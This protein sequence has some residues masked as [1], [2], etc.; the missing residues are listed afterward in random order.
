MIEGRLFVVVEHQCIV[1][2]LRKMLYKD[3]DHSWDRSVTSLNHS[4]SNL[5][6]FCKCAFLPNWLGRR[7]HGCVAIFCTCLHMCLHVYTHMFIMFACLYMFLLLRWILLMIADYHPIVCAF[8]NVT[9]SNIHMYVYINKYIYIYT[10]RFVLLHSNYFK[11]LILYDYMWLYVK[12]KMHPCATRGS[13]SQAILPRLPAPHS[14]FDHRRPVCCES[15][16]GMAIMGDI[17][18]KFSW[19]KLSGFL[20]FFSHTGRIYHYTW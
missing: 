17:S 9:V 19:W 7:S 6:P 20:F 12:K 3:K 15:R 8:A 4:E 11:M 13:T 14:G 16:R 10:R 1:P 18:K 5:A 2:L